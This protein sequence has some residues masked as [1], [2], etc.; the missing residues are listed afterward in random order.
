[1]KYRRKFGMF[2]QHFRLS[3]TLKEIAPQY[4]L[5]VVCMMKNESRYLRE[6]LEYHL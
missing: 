1:M 2:L 6:W 5:S 3:K 4:Y